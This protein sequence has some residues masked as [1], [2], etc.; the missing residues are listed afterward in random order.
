MGSTDGKAAL[1]KLEM[2]HVREP[3]PSPIEAFGPRLPGAD[4]RPRSFSPF[5]V[6]HVQSMAISL[7][8]KLLATGAE[9]GKVRLWDMEN[10]KPRGAYSDAKAKRRVTALVTSLAFSPD[11]KRLAA[12][13]PFD[14][15]QSSIPR[16]AIGAPCNCR[17]AK[18]TMDFK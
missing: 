13:R 2:K 12:L 6:H 8:G 4:G 10:A 11:G 1:W 14:D 5:H 9:E 15:G 17:S 3:G 7:D 18:R 16:L